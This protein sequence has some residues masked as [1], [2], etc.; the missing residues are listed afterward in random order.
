M[1]SLDSLLLRSITA[2]SETTTPEDYDPQYILQLLA[3]VLF[4]Q[5]TSPRQGFLP[6][7]MV[8]TY[9]GELYL[10]PGNYNDLYSLPPTDNAVHGRFRLFKLDLFPASRIP[11][12]MIT[13][14]WSLVNRGISVN[15]MSDSEDILRSSIKYYLCREDSLCQ[16][17]TDNLDSSLFSWLLLV[18]SN[19][20]VKVNTCYL[21]Q[22]MHCRWSDDNLPSTLDSNDSTREKIFSMVMHDSDY[23]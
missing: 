22:P 3:K 16:D 15:V 2:T 1:P 20:K 19:C 5:S 12:N 23:N 10:R 9:T 11:I 4:S 21:D 18:I 6:N 17:W 7:L 13:Y 8:L 14:L